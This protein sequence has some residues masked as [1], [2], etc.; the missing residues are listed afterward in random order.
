MKF[1]TN[2]KCGGCVSAIGD[3]LN[4]VIKPEEWHIDLNTPEKLL[5]VTANVSPETII[6]LVADAGF[7][8]QQ[9]L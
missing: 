5:K 2:A 7:K 6:A 8:A 9:L 1:K 4:K 3:K